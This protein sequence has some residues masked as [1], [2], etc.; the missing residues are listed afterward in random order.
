LRVVCGG[1]ARPGRPDA[2]IEDAIYDLKAINLNRKPEVDTRT[3]KVLIEII[4]AKAGEV[5]EALKRLREVRS[6]L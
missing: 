4:E 5:A 1:V 3:P 2:S 6:G